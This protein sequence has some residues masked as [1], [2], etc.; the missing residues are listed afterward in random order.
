MPVCGQEGSGR[1]G[2]RAIALS[3][4]RMGLGT[5]RTVNNLSH[6]TDILPTFTDLLD[7]D[8]PE[9]GINDGVSLKPIIKNLDII[10][11]NQ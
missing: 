4:G 2:H 9:T 8:V 3:A 10:D 11:E 1:G 7:F 6:I 5:P